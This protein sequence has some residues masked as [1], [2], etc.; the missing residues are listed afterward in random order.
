MI[1]FRVITLA[2]MAICGLGVICDK[3][4]RQYTGAVAVT[5]LL[6]LA[7]VLVAG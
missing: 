7:S 3:E 5:G 1:V 4:K 2:T 6:Y